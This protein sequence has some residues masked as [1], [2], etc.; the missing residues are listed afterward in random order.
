MS[1][2]GSRDGRR[3]ASGS[4][5]GECLAWRATSTGSSGTSTASPV[6]SPGAGGWGIRPVEALVGGAGAGEAP[7]RGPAAT[8]E[9]FAPGPIPA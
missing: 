4:T 2:P 8:A 6:D 9:L 3:G 5:R 7:A 1:R